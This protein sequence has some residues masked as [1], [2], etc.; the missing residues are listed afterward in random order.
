MQVKGT[1]FS[2]D[3]LAAQRT[4]F[5]KQG[6]LHLAAAFPAA[7][8]DEVRELLD[9][10]F[11]RYAQLPKA[12]KREIAT[13]VP[14]A[15]GR[16][17]SP[18]LSRTLWLEPALAKT[19]LFKCCQALASEMAGHKVRYVYDHAIYK[20]PAEPSGATP[21]HQDQ[22]FAG[23][24]TPLRTF[25]FWIPLQD[26]LENDGCMHYLPHS[27]QAGLVK[28]QRGRAAQDLHATGFDEGLALPCP[29]VRGGCLIHGPLTLHRTGPNIG[30]NLRRAWILHF[31]P[32][33]WFGKLHPVRVGERIAAWIDHR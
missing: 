6:F 9:G 20:L 7:A 5:E 24:R 30:T 18:E 13:Q 21:W 29:T 33:G 23:Y 27:H 10:L 25:H 2:P 32:M 26:T 17:I 14:L 11:A 4:Q 16:L 22:A 12:L 31:G 1:L 15:T 28:H 3:Q 8:V 19:E